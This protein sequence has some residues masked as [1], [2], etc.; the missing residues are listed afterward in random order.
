MT[1]MDKLMEEI[2]AENLYHIYF[3]DPTEEDL[4][5]MAKEQEQ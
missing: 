1:E 4:E 5:Q 3:P 2:K